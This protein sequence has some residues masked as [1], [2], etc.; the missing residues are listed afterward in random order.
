MVS[1]KCTNRVTR[2]RQLLSTYLTS[3]GSGPGFRKFVRKSV[4]LEK[5]RFPEIS[6]EICDAREIYQ[7]PANGCKLIL[8]KLLGQ[9][10]SNV[11]AHLAYE[12]VYPALCRPW[13]WPWRW[14]WCGRGGR[15]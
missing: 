6:R 11:Q 7:A 15:G 9:Q 5:K 2:S 8:G 10:P 4:T 3:I 1:C 13:R 14:P 12:L